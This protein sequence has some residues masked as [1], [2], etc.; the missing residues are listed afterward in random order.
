MTPDRSIAISGRLAPGDK[1]GFGWRG[2]GW[3]IGVV[4]G[5]LG[6]GGLLVMVGT[7]LVAGGWVWLGAAAIGGGNWIF[8]VGGANRVFPGRVIKVSEAWEWAAAG[9]MGMAVV[10]WVATLTAGGIW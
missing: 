4:G 2:M 6:W 5:A 7:V 1:V 9:I 3:R 8:A 10:G